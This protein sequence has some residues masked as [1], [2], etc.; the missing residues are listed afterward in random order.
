MTAIDKVFY[1]I[2][3]VL[4]KT[5]PVNSWK[6]T[7]G[8]VRAGYAI[9]RILASKPWSYGEHTHSGF[10]EYLYMLDGEL[11]H[12][13][14]GQRVLQKEGE[15]VLVREK[16]IHS[17][18]GNRFT[19]VNVMFPTESLQRLEGF[20]G[21]KGIVD[22]L[23]GSSQPSALMEGESAD[24]FASLIR[25]M[26]TNSASK[27]GRYVFAQFQILAAMNCLKSVTSREF[28]PGMPDWLCGTV[29]WIDQQR[30][31]PPHLKD[32]VRHSCRCQEHF[33]RLFSY[34]VGV[35]PT[36]YIGRMRIDRA[37]ELLVTTNYS[38]QQICY[39]LGF[40]NQSYFYRL[41]RSYKNK[42]PLAY[43]RENG[44]RSV[45]T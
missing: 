11:D 39:E 20:V 1:Y 36:K 18:C 2:D 5:I 25:D 30:D 10:C 44:P 45:H 40:E 17:L 15:L 13:L 23:L 7:A 31:H 9:Q 4:M 14:N 29:E 3:I 16:D 37:A 41:F 24:H 38:V 22:R 32:I 21:E 42:S 34:Y 28:S 26:L 8:M 27:V 35:S 12:R 33:T 19:Y 43:R 6:E